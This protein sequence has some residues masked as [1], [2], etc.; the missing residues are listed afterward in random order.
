M[1]GGPRAPTTVRRSAGSRFAAATL[2]DGYLH[3]PDK[4]AEAMT[5][6]GWFVTGDAA[7]VG[8]DG[9]H[10][11]V[12]RASVDIIK[13]GGYKVGAGEVETALLSHR[14]VERGRGD[15]CGRRRPGRADRRVRRGRR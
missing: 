11:I 4:T 9:F 5:D 15:R 14:S 12:G 1:L 3:L 6:D 2:F 8:P 13:S 10:R 7:T